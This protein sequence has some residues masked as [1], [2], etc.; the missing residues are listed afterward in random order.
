MKTARGFV[1]A[2]LL[3][4]LCGVFP[5]IASASGLQVDPL[6]ITV[7]NYGDLTVKNTGNDPVRLSLNGYVWTQNAD[8]QKHTEDSAAITYFPKVFSVAPG[9]TQRVRVGIAG[10]PANLERAFRLYVTELPP[11]PSPELQQATGAQLRVLTRIDLPVFQVLPSAGPAVA[12]IDHALA[13]AKGVRF[14]LENSGAR[15]LAPSKLV[16]TAKDASGATVT[17]ATVDEWYVLA[18]SERSADLDLPDGACAKIASYA[19]SWMPTVGDKALATATLSSPG[20]K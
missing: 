16:V 6:M 9:A 3:S 10:A 15:H 7:T 19:L 20:C 17:T 14:V 2:C 5:S 8:E 12:K 4:A 1:L 18:H 11:P 13:T